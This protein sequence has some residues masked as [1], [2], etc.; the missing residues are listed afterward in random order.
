MTLRMVQLARAGRL[1]EA[2]EVLR[3][4]LADAPTD[5]PMLYNLACL[6]LYLQENDQALDDLE[7]ALANGYTNF[8]LIETD[9]DLNPLRENPRFTEMVARFEEE[10]RQEFLDRALYLDEGY[11]AEG[12]L[13]Q[14]APGLAAMVGDSRPE[15]SVSFDSKNLL[16]TLSVK[17][18]DGGADGPPWQGG[19]GVLV[20]LVHPI[21]PDDYESRRYF[22]F[23]FF[24]GE[25]RPQAALVGM[26]GQVL[27]KTEPD[28][29]PVITHGKSRTTY[30]IAIPWEN[31]T[32]YAPPLDQEMG[33]N[34]FYLGVGRGASRPVFALM[35]EDRLSFEAAPWRRYVPV[36]FLDSDRTVPVMRGRLY[37]RLAMGDSLGVQLAIWSDAQGRA[38]CRFTMH[39]L[40]QSEVMVG[41]PVVMDF[42]CETE[43]NFFNTYLPLQDVASGS[44]LLRTE[45]T[46]PDGIVFSLEFP[47]DNLEQDWA[48]TLN[49]R[50]YAIK[51]P[52]Q[53]ILNYHLF[54]L[55]RQAEVRHPQDDASDLHR[56]RAEVIRLI[57]L[58]ETGGSCLPESG[59]FRGGITSDVMTQRSCAMYL[60]RG[61]RQW[62]KPQLVMVLP[63]EPGSEDDLARSLGT[64]L[65]GKL[66]A[67]VLVP[68]SHGFTGLAPEKSAEETVLALQWAQTLFPTGEVILAGLG[69]GTDAALEASLRR[70]DLSQAVLLDGDQIFQ[71]M[72]GFSEAEVRK[73]LGSRSNPH[74]Y[75]LS[76]GSLASPR[77]PVLVAVMQKQG[78]QVHSVPIQASA[79]DA[80]ILASW[81]LSGR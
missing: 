67:I 4:Y 70:P 32:P 54:S 40:G 14:P 10:F 37:E 19:S 17:G 66:E 24:G 9:R 76:S 33:L 47:F 5:G 28:L 68:Q 38:E 72:S 59:L 46:E 2:R 12:I 30:E 39:P 56:A 15:V 48:S 3:V 45:V 65:E 11:T 44:Y 21:S 51:S 18:V 41:D 77:L 63:P 13:L 80:E 16:V 35:N 25:D 22:S 34:I 23:G 49:E 78:F 57:E 64:A 43:L 55:V 73:A 71:D 52:E 58:V 60:P 61:Y 8:R 79:L 29:S 36:H 7:L 31:F 74:Q 6:D 81:L 42:A 26:H 27:L 20:N 50:V 75:I 53:S 69:Q 62:A 1:S